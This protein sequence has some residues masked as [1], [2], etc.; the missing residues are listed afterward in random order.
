MVKYSSFFLTWLATKKN[1]TNTQ[2]GAP[3]PLRLAFDF[4]A[5]MKLAGKS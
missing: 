3:Y 4:I 2:K 1:Q 5:N